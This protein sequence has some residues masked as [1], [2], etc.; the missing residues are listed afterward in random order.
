MSIFLDTCLFFGT[1]NINDALHKDAIAIYVSAFSGRWGMIYTSDY[2]IDETSTL[3]K[4]KASPSLSLQFLKAVIESKGI[5]IITI[6]GEIFERSCKIFEKYHEKPGLSF[7]DAATISVMKSL[8][9][10]ALA[11]FDER[12]FEGII[13]Q[14]VGKDFWSS[15]SEGERKQIEKTINSYRLK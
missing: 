1:Y 10:D 4:V 9:L 15:L 5:S 6:D 8:E 3:L 14:R 13:D 2:I 11:S 7:T 12:S